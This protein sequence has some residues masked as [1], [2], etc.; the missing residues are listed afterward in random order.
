MTAHSVRHLRVCCN[1][2][3]LGDRF[4]MIQTPEGLEHQECWTERQADL[5]T[6]VLALPKTES[7]KLMLCVI[8]DEAMSA[9]L[10]RAP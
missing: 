10:N 3:G 8:G 2:R 5:V 6:A 7:D 4:A 1:C 9:L